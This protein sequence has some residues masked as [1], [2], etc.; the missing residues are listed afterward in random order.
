MKKLTLIFAVILSSIAFTTAIA[1]DAK[2]AGK[3]EGN[4]E[5]K[6]GNKEMKDKNPEDIAQKRSE[7]WKK[8]LG[9]SDEQ[10]A[11]LKT[12]ISERITKNKAAKALTD[13]VAKKTAVTAAKTEF[14]TKVKSIF[15]PE[16]Y[17]KFIA[18]RNELKAKQKAKKEVSEE[19]EDME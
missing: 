11:Q 1:Q 5:M 4:K 17:T 2:K 13:K 10:T 3:K 12:A 9:L 6:G 14:D 8:E 15:T 16:Q 7:M 19:D 18:K